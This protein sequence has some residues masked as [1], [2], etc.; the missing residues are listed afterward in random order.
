[1]WTQENSQEDPVAGWNTVEALKQR[2][3]WITNSAPDYLFKVDDHLEVKDENGAV[4]TGPLDD[5][6]VVFLSGKHG[7][8]TDGWFKKGYVIG[9]GLKLN[10]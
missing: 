5:N 7:M 4:V 6:A 10:Q 9:P 2:I 3:G 1:M 8:P